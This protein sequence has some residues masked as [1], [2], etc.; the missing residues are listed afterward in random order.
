ME[1]VGGDFFDFYKI[2]KFQGIFICDVSGHGLTAA[3]IT[4]IVKTLLETAGD[5]KISPGFLLDHLN[6]L[7]IGLSDDKH[8]T[9]FNCL[10][11][12]VTKKIRYSNAGHNPPLHISDGVIKKLKTT[13]T[14]IGC[15]DNV[16]Y[17]EEDI[18]LKKDDKIIF[19]TDGL[20][21]AKNNEEFF[22]DRALKFIEENYQMDIV[23]LL[24]ELNSELK[25][26]MGTKP[27]DDDVCII[28]MEVH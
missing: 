15:F 21:E 24:E 26:F 12:P 16:E 7:L 20:V 22:K 27:F 18:S 11:N 9:A 8:L 3:F 10:Y 14:L 2:S 23:Q 4:S 28:G 19:Y 1:A 25:K 5:K 17:N 13:G 6:R